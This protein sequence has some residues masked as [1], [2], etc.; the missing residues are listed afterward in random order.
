MF[1]RGYRCG[2]SPGEAMEYRPAGGGHRPV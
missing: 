1:G 2:G